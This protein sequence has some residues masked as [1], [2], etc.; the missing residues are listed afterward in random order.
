MGQKYQSATGPINESLNKQVITSCLLAPTLFFRAP[1]INFAFYEC[2]FLT[3]IYCGVMQANSDYW[4]LK[5]HL[6][7][8]LAFH[9]PLLVTALYGVMILFLFK[10]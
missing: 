10:D 2:M 7:R 6:F 4:L 5:S 8:L 1:Q 9:Y 3:K